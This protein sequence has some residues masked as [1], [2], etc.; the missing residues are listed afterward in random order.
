MRPKL[1][2]FRTSNLF[3]LSYS[4]KKGSQIL[5]VC[6]GFHGDSELDCSKNAYW[7][8]QRLSRERVRYSDKD[9]VVLD[10]NKLGDCNSPFVLI[11]DSQHQKRNEHRCQIIGGGLISS[12]PHI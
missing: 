10:L 8:E 1:S 6:W 11:H 12:D 4:S 9:D 2:G 7:Y 5:S 3:Q